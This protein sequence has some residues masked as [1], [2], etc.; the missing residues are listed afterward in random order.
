MTTTRMMTNA[1]GTPTAV[2]EHRAYK[3]E[4]TSLILV[5]ENWLINFHPADR[6]IYYFETLI[7]ITRFVN[8]KFRNGWMELKTFPFMP[9]VNHMLC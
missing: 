2:P 4:Q 7:H 3:I 5:L 8:Q 6:E 9:T 1:T